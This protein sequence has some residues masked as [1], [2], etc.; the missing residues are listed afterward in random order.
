MNRAGLI[1]LGAGAGIAAI[2]IK[3][4]T[5]SVSGLDVG[6]IGADVASGVADFLDN[7]GAGG[8][9]KV[10]S[11]KNVDRSALGVKNVQAF[12][13]VI[14][15]GE[16]TL[17][18]NG[19]RRIFGGQL[20]DNFADHPRIKVTKS[21]YTSSASGAY[22]MKIST[23]DETKAA[24]NLQDFSPASQDLA[25]LGRIAARGALQ[26]VIAGNFEKAVSKLNQEW[27]SLPGATVGQ[28]T[29]SMQK[30]KALYLSLGGT[31]S[32]ATYA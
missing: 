24:M 20:F 21:G 18:A 12:L 10:S 6:T 17:D 3:N 2:L 4:N 9:V 14:R 28:P 15:N 13:K 32:G 23:W 16:G 31:T 26:D 5:D 11:M 25:A 1:I 29:V 8:M 30:A 7:I 22:Q 19:Y 27:V